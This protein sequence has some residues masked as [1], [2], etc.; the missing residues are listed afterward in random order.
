M[1]VV[2]RDVGLEGAMY[3]GEEH[4]LIDTVSVGVHGGLGEDLWIR[5]MHELGQPWREFVSWGMPVLVHMMR[6]M[7]YRIR[8]R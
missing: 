2:T 7:M 1:R 4:G 3:S 6:S 8:W 5:V